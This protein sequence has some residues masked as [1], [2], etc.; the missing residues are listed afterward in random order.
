MTQEQQKGY[1]AELLSHVDCKAEAFYVL[2]HQAAEGLL[3]AR[4]YGDIAKLLGFPIAEEEKNEV[5]KSIVNVANTLKPR[6]KKTARVQSKA[7]KA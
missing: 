4:D 3:H 2:S 6:K 1:V 5:Y 7:I